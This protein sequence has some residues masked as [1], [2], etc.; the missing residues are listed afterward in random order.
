MENQKLK[1][2]KSVVANADPREREYVL[3]DSAIAGFG[4]RVRPSGAKSYVFVY[5]TPGGRSGTV[6]RVTIDANNPDRAREQ[7]KA[8]AG[9][10]HGGANPAAEKAEEKREAERLK[11]APT[12]GDILNRFIAD[13]AKEELKPKTADEYERIV[14]K[15]LK[16]R[17]GGLKIDAMLPK[18]I[19]E[20]YRAM[21]STPTQAAVAVRVLSSAMSWAEEAGLRSPGPNPA[22][23]RLKGARRR[24]RLFSDTEVTRLLSTIDDM[25]K[26]GK[27]IAPVALGLRLLFATGC[28]AGE[29]CDLQW[30]NVDLDEGLMRWPNSKT[31]FLEKPITDEARELLE[32]ADR[33][34]GLPWVCPSPFFKRLRVETLEAGFE[35]V[36]KAAKV[37]ANENA[38]LHL[39]RH[40]FAT[41]IYT[42]KSVPLPLQ[43]AI[44]GHG[45]VAT[46]M[47]YAHVSREELTRVAKDA[48][49]RRTTALKA[50]EKK[51]RVVALRPDQ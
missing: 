48:G 32:K 36:M 4:L 21:R 26:D 13:H 35:R 49:R 2:S 27:I 23:I 47:R 17:L 46:A 3:W 10:F 38:T 5:R 20:M 39:I 51:G 11:L 30:E 1:I 50:A 45:S 34:V 28:R 33:K 8:L 42:D 15:I 16:P 22:S 7:A 18:D 31:G 24:Q 40:W 14:Q 25:E 44:M 29:I 37:P 9:Q 43:M 41:K 12:V 6:K 19:A